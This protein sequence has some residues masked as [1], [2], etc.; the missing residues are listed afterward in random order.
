[1]GGEREGLEELDWQGR[2][3]LDHQVAARE[4]MGL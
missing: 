3:D 4:M 1:V 2:E